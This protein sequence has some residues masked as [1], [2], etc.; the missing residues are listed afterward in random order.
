MVQVLPGQADKTMLYPRVIFG[1][2]LGAGL[3]A[4]AD[5]GFSIVIRAGDSMSAG[6]QWAIGIGA[7]GSPPSN[8]ALVTPGFAPQNFGEWLGGTGYQTTRNFQI[9]Y[10]NNLNQAFVRVYDGAGLTFDEV[11]YTPAGAGSVS[12]DRIWSIPQMTATAEAQGLSGAVTIDNLALSGAMAILQPLQLA[13]IQASQT[14]STDTATRLEPVLF[15][16]PGSGAAGDWILTGRI[17]FSGLQVIWGTP[18]RLRF[19]LDVQS[20]DT[21]EPATFA[22]LGFGLLILSVL[23]LKRKS[24]SGLK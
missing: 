19:G 1:M 8:T 5:F 10:R 22:L 20:A 24:S 13:P 6:Q 16:D 21:P 7:P 23:R 3:L 4:A 18:G 9:G 15:R 12:L 14:G 11:T 17:S 2:L